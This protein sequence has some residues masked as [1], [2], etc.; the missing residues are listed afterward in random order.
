[1]KSL[2][3]LFLLGI[4]IGLSLGFNRDKLRNLLTTKLQKVGQKLN[5]PQK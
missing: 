3:L 4:A 1:M 2:I 5:P